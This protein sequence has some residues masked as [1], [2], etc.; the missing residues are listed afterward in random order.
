MKRFFV[1]ALLLLAAPLLLFAKDYK[2][3]TFHTDNAGKVIFDHDVHLKKLANDC[4]VCHSSLYQIGKKNPVVTMAE[5]EKGKSCGFC[6]NKVRAFSVSE[7]VRCHIVDKVPIVIPDFGTLL[8]DHKFHLGLYTCADCHNKYFYA[9]SGKNPHVTMKQMEGGKSCG[10][11]HD[12]KTGFS[13]KGDCVR[14]HIVKDI[15]FA[16]ADP[17]SHSYHLK[18]FGCYDCHSKLFIAGPNAKRHTMKE[19]ETGS[20]CGGCHDAKTAFSVKGD[21]NR[22]HKSV[23]DVSFKASKALFPHTFHLTIY[24]CADCHSGIYT[25]GPR[26]TPYTMADMEKKI[27]RSCGACHEGD[28]AFSAWGS[29]NRCHTETKELEWK[30]PGAGKAVFSHSYHMGKKFSCGDCHF[31]IFA[32]GTMAKRFTMKQMEKGDSCGACHD[33]KGAF[34][35]SANCG[36]CHPVKDIDF[37]LGG[38]FSHSVHYALYSCTACHNKLFKDGVGNKSRTMPDMEKGLSCGACHLSGKDAFTVSGNCGRCHNGAPELQMQSQ[39]AGPTPFSH[40]IHTSVYKCD[41]CHNK[42]FTTG[43]AAKRYSMSQME[44]GKS[45]GACH[46]DKDAFTAAANCTRCHPVKDIP[47]KNWGG[48]FKHSVHITLYRCNRCHDSIFVAGPGRRSY[49]M[50]DMESGKSCGACHD[51]KEAFSVKKDCDKCHPQTKAIKYDFPDK[52]TSSAYFSHKLHKTKG[53]KCTDCHYKIFKTGVNRR[54][55]SMA[56]MQSA[57]SCG[58]CHA[59]NITGSPNCAKCHKGDSE[60]M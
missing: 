16:A 49:T 45:C 59:Y 43:V 44:A 2:K 38:K 55:Y 31:G 35:V 56:E 13:V 5:M 37:V 8:F 14:C 32:T 23:G 24:R 33:G 27:G 39:G 9:Q 12:G 6:H 58:A 26:R 19:M 7:C 10:A 1:S 22:C 36:R 60:V 52:K 40:Q 18:M 3:V 30:I 51:G 41:D 34:S 54:S 48:L 50:P 47:Y 15:S 57:K 29:C 17:F 11:C 28:M 25:A 42:V 46:N 20:S 53:Y 4:T 21:C